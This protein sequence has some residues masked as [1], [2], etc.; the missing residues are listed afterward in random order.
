MSSGA[1]VWS[2]L[3]ISERAFELVLHELGEVGVDLFHGVSDA[4]CDALEDESAHAGED[5]EAEA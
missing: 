4:V 2:K 3:W 5:R 1:M